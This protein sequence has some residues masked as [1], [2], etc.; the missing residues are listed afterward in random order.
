MINNDPITCKCKLK[1]HSTKN[2]KKNYERKERVE[3]HLEPASETVTCKTSIH[4]QECDILSHEC[5]FIQ[6]LN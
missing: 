6:K 2:E 3:R 5:G 4:V 1:Q